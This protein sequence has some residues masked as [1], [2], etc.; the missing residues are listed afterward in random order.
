[1]KY[2]NKCFDGL[3]IMYFEFCANINQ[4][5]N[6]LLVKKEKAS[7]SSIFI[8]WA[9]TAVLNTNMIGDLNRVSY[10]Q[11]RHIQNHNARWAG[12]NLFSI[13]KTNNLSKRTRV[14]KKSSQA[15]EHTTHVNIPW[16]QSAK[17]PQK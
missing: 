6:S 2:D 16:F 15:R 10:V 17:N 13:I 12:L 8:A 11:W 4:G 14:L 9:Y 3:T 5:I 1:M 7:F